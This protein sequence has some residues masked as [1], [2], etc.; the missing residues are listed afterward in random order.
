MITLKLIRLREFGFFL[1]LESW[2]RSSDF[3]SRRLEKSKTSN[4]KITK[5]NVTT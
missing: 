5:K 3:A 4:I 1:L 2:T